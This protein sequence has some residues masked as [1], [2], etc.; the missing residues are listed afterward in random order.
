MRPKSDLR[1]SA[2]RAKNPGAAPATADF[3]VVGGGIIGI[4]IALDLARRFRG[5][6]IA[7]IEKEDE[8]GMHASGRN[9]G[10]LHA[11]FYYSADSLKARFS[12]EGN[13]A[14][15]AYCVER[16]LRINRCGK[17]V[18]AQDESE[19]AGLDELLRRGRVNNVRLEEITDAEARKI[20]LRVRT[21]QR[22]IFSPT[23]SA[24]DP[25]EVTLSLA[26]DAEKAGVA[27]TRQTKYLGRDGSTVR[28][29]SGTIDCG[30]VVNAAGLY[31]DRVA[32]D[33]GFSDNYRILPFKGVY[34]Y[35][36]EGETIRTNIY[37]VPN[38]AN[39]FLGVHFTV[40]AHGRTKIG[41]TAIP[42]FWREQYGWIAGFSGREL[43]DIITRELG[44]LARNDFSFRSLAVSELK[45]YRR[46]NLVALASK[47][48]RDLDPRRY[49]HW[50]KPGIRAQLLDIRT[51]RL[52]T[53]FHVEG[54]DRS[55]HVLNAVS[56]AFTSS[57]PFASYVVDRIQAEVK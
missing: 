29:S 50:G 32:R 14:L 9:S 35:A 40:T 27:I 33:Y 53:D 55:M 20:E 43:A 24:V 5:Q 49:T 17:L 37:P 57:I 44:L 16:G 52:V 31:A 48:V 38:L 41:P 13:A 47:M 30:Y 4:T 10:I 25:T 19:L 1:A 54:D 15:T 26:A 7:L 21:F 51:R 6:S 8:L 56:P 23:T 18:V 46:S 28:T 42:A 2:S 45:K 34:L 11:G 12:R 39:P 36:D 22:A 3:L